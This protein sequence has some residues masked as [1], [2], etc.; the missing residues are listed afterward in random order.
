[1]YDLYDRRVFENTSLN[2]SNEVV[3]VIALNSVPIQYTGWYS[4]AVSKICRGV[5]LLYVN[6]ENLTSTC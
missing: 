4:V 2:L 3:L 6:L 5:S 1:M